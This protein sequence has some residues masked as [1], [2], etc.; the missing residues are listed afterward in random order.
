MIISSVWNLFVKFWSL[1][2]NSQLFCR[3]EDL[4]FS[5]SWCLKVSIILSENW[6]SRYL[7]SAFFALRYGNIKEARNSIY[8]DDL[9][10]PLPIK[11]RVIVQ[12][13]YFMILIINKLSYVILRSLK[14]HP[15]NTYAKF[16]EKLTFLTSWYAHV[17][18][19]IRELEMLVFR[20]I[21]RTY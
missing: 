20:K 7:S 18:V 8:S 12:V 21:L 6:S 13:P 15:Y 11:L 10:R 2:T 17:C 3:H 1:M 4:I 16:S 19:R 14:D 9:Y 5:L